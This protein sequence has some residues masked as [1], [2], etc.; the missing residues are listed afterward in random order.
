MQGNTPFTV[1]TRI[2]C[3]ERAQVC[4]CKCWAPQYLFLTPAITPPSLFSRPRPD[5]CV[6]RRRRVRGFVSESK[7]ESQ[8][9][10][11]P[12]FLPFPVLLPRGSTRAE[13]VQSCYGPRLQ[14]GS[15]IR[16]LLPPREN[17]WPPETHEYD[18]ALGI[19]RSSSEG[20]R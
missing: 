19:K 5:C 18:G 20:E 13:R 1:R 16:N 12:T 8:F 6:L 3:F 4:I 17:T 9:G 7:Q 11:P 15:D 2:T 14:E 10:V